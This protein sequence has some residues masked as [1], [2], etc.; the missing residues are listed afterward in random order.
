M[1]SIN[2]KK[3]SLDSSKVCMY[4]KSVPLTYKQIVQYIQL[5][6]H[7]HQYSRNIL[8]PDVGNICS[9]HTIIKNS[10]FYDESLNF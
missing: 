8:N 1:S 10:T 7:A 2:L 5:I 9:N 3:S 4:N 6:A